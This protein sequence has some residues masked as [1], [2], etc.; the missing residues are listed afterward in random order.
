MIK[1]AARA[2][3][4]T[5]SDTRSR[6]RRA[7]RPASWKKRIKTAFA[8][9]LLVVETAIALGLVC[10][11]AIFWNFS[12]E[13]PTFESIITDNQEPVSTKIWSD[14]GV[15]LGKLDVENRQPILLKDLGKSKVVDATIAIEDHRFYEHPGVDVV[16]IGR[17]LLANLRGSTLKQ[18]ASTLTQQLIRQ[19]GI[20]AQFGLNAE[21]RF[22]RKIRE[23]L[24]ALRV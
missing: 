11:L 7:A 14:D 16:G 18:G 19:P 6:S 13:L 15:L 20:G 9:A 17:A 24:L 22:S 23:W 10:A 4:P 12:R 8:M 5:R 2:A 21:K 1:N 3:V